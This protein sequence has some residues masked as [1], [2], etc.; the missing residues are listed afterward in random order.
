ME[1]NPNAYF[2]LHV[3]PGQVKRAGPLDADEQK[4]FLWVMKI[5]PLSSGKWGL[6]ARNITNRVGY[7]CRNFYHRFLA[8]RG[9]DASTSDR[10]DNAQP[11]DARDA[12]SEEPPQSGAEAERAPPANGTQGE[13]KSQVRQVSAAAREMS[14]CGIS[15]KALIRDVANIPSK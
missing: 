5:H 2:Y 9:L 3:A 6:F 13:E 1:S 14:G 15:V 7:Q 11:E 12:P 8:G 10:G 4:L